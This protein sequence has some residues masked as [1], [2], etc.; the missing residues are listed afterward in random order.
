M[1]ARERIINAAKELFSSKGYSNTSVEEIVRHAGLSK[2]AFYFYFD[3]KDQ[4]ME[5]I[6]NQMAEKTKSIMRS[7]LE[8]DVSSEEAI[9]GHI[10]EFL[11]E[12]YED[13]HIAYVF[14]FELLC[15]KES[16]R[17]LYYKHMEEIRALLGQMVGRGYERGEFR[18]GRPETLV[19]LILGYMRLVYVEKLL[20]NGAS[21][22]EVLEEAREGLEFILRGLTCG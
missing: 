3:S 18:R 19:N 17:R 7:W 12:C 1:N 15:S 22:K 4:L 8:R 13:R 21:L 6:V 5:E 9:K 16:F 2:G 11:T 20:L 14:F 10:E